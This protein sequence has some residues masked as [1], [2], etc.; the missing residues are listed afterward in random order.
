MAEEQRRSAEVRQGFEKGQGDGEGHQP[1]PNQDN[2]AT[3]RDELGIAP[4]R[5]R[6]LCV[7]IL[8]GEGF[9]NEHYQPDDVGQGAVGQQV[10]VWGDPGDDGS[11]LEAFEAQDDGG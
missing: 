9:A 10:Y 2:E 1:G 6:Q 4:L 11:L 3:S 8:Q 5:S 7:G